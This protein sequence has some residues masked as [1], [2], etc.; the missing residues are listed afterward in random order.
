MW[1]NHPASGVGGPVEPIQTLVLYSGLRHRGV[2]IPGEAVDAG[3]ERVDRW[4]DFVD[5]TGS[6]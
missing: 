1:L 4:P 6:R 2:P 3:R 5:P